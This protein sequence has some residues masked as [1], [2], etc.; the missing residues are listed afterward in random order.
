MSP[1]PEF[2]AHLGL[3]KYPKINFEKTFWT[4]KTIR[5]YW[6]IFGLYKKVYIDFWDPT[7]NIKMHLC[8]IM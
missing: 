4:K 3:S 5:E 2:M 8:M 6:A 7:L 1:I